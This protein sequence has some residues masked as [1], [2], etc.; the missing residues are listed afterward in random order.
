MLKSK[1]KHSSKKINNIINYIGASLSF[2]LIYSSHR[3]KKKKEESA[4][5]DKIVVN[6]YGICTLSF[7]RF[8]YIINMFN[9]LK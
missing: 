9:I 3:V 1:W 4:V 2:R 6:K 5:R 7:F 8:Y